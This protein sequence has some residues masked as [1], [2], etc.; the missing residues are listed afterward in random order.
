MAG[1][2]V[3]GLGPLVITPSPPPLNAS[4]DRDMLTEEG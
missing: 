1:G 3:A 4:E 2:S